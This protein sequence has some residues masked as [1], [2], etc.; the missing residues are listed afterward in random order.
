MVLGLVV[1]G[2]AKPKPVEPV[3]RR[4]PAALISSASLFEARKFAGT[5][6]VAGS[7][8]PGCIGAEQVWTQAAGGWDISGVDCTGATPAALSGHADLVGPGGRILPQGGYGDEPLWVL[9][10]DQ[11]YRVAVLGAPSG[12]HAVNLTRPGMARGDLL[13]AAKEV[14]DFNGFS[15]DGLA[16]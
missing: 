10:V 6:R 16:K 4:D 13:R 14:M 3:N 1:F 12:H 2:C 9:W 5:W 7:Y 8:T 15:P 11:D